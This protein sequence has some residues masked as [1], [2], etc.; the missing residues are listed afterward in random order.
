LKTAWPPSSPPGPDA[1]PAAD[2]LI[3]FEVLADAQSA[4]RL[5]DALLEVGALS[6][7]VDDAA[8]VRDEEAVFAEPGEPPAGL[9]RINRLRVLLAPGQEPRDVLAEAAR[10]TGQPPPPI[11]AVR[12]IGAQD[13][14]RASQAQFPA[15]QFGRLWVVPS[16]IEPPDPSAV[17]LRLDPGLAFGTGSHPSTRLCLRWLEAHVRPGDRV[18]DYGCGSG[19]LSIAAAMLGAAAVAGVDIDPLALAAARENARRNGIR[20]DYTAPDRLRRHSPKARFDV[21]IANILANPLI[22]LAPVLVGHLAP[23]GSIVL[24]GVLAR[25][26]DALAEAYRAADPRVQLSPWGAEGDWV[27][28][29]ARRASR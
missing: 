18:L 15:V 2:G 3:E 12:R 19:I 28:L 23:G 14:V 13:W 26:V 4:E 17:N 8:A 22:V 29:A 10:R 27:C 21:V 16:W 20:A 9:W 25:Q 6:V 11:G 24:A 7:D 1:D 5:S